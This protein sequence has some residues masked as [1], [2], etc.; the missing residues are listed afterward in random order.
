MQPWTIVLLTRIQR[1]FLA[2]CKFFR[3]NFAM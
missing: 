1:L 3:I 2:T